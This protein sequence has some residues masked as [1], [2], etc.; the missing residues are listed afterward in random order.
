MKFHEKISSEAAVRLRSSFFYRCCYNLQMQVRA[1]RRG[2]QTALGNQRRNG[3]L[4]STR[5]A[6]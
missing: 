5:L 1:E 2:F 4:Y 6:G 3:H